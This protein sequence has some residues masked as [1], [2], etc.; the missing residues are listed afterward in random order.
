MVELRHSNGSPVCV[1]Y[2]T[3]GF[4]SPESQGPI[5]NFNLLRPNGELVGYSE[6]C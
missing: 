5:V 3:G 6:V 4:G 1:L 2:C